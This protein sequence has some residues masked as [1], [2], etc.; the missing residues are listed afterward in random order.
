MEGIK[1]KADFYGF[2]YF[3]VGLLVYLY[4]LSVPH[5]MQDLSFPTRDRTHAP[6][7]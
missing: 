4:F 7:Q 6:P 3:L 5:P 2:N 1:A